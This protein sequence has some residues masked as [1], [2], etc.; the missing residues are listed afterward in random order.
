MSSR[1]GNSSSE[2]MEVTV[3]LQ[4]NQGKVVMGNCVLKKM[5][6]LLIIGTSLCLME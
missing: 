4:L 3:E 2:I 1:D 5:R 6:N